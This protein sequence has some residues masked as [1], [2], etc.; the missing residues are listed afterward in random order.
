NRVINHSDPGNA[1]IERLQTAL[2]GELRGRYLN[3]AWIEPLMAHGYAGAR[4]MGSE[5]LEYLW[6]W[7]VTN[8]EI[9]RSWAWDEVKAVYF[10]DRYELGLDE[11]LAEGNNAHVKANMLAILLVAAHKGF[12]EAS[13]ETL[14][15]VAGEFATLVTENGLPG[16][17]HTTPDHPMLEWIQ[18][19]LSAELR[20][21]LQRAIDNARGAPRR[22]D[23]AAA[24]TISELSGAAEDQQQGADG[25]QASERG[26]GADGAPS[27]GL[28]LL[29]AA[30]ALVAA[31][32]ATGLRHRARSAGGNHV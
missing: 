25:A 27:R 21:A 9:V 19:Q 2:L 11:F 10:D 26:E 23:S 6:G 3:P 5:F 4:T 13:P 29:L 32:M 14:A 22:P 31:G 18:P 24:S 16:S 8:P 30:F 12:W 20:D 1:R 28:W 7:Q 17:G 15:E